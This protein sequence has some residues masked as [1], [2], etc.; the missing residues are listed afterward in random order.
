MVSRGRP[1]TFDRTEALSRAMEVFWSQGY[2]GAS[3]TELTKA[4]GIGS[5]SL[6]AAFGSKE[7]LFRE[8]VEHYGRTE[9]PEIQAAMDAAPSAR[10]AV[11]AY[12][13]ASA[14][15]FTRPGKP[16]G[17]M[18]VLSGL[19]AA[20]ASQSVCDGLRASRAGA[21]TDLEL[22]LRGAIARGELPAEFNASAVA[23]FYVTVQ[24]GMSIQARDG[25]SRETLLNIAR[26]AMTAWA[27][28]VGM[29]P[30]AR[31]SDRRKR[32]G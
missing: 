5:P 19:T 8:A 29:Q 18:V 31:G 26:A 1:R 27:P 9:G 23:A 3:M 17:C 22:R 24:Q 6:Y 11:E 21:V 20:D 12:L 16:R 14:R 2:E 7:E 15:T 13:T 32:A 10:E 25:A 4:M 30:A 28:L